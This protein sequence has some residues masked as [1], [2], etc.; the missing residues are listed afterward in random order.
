[1]AATKIGSV[2]SGVSRKSYNVHWDKSDLE[3]YVDKGGLTYIG[4]AHS[5]GE[6]MDIAEAWLHN[7]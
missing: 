2:E 1:M 4:E 5:A 7:K 3:V 6:A